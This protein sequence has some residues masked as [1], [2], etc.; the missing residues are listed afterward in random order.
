MRSSPP[1]FIILMIGVCLQPGFSANAFAQEHNPK[2]KP[3]QS[4]L[5]DKQLELWND[6]EFQRRFTESYIA[7]TDIEPTITVT[8]RE[9][10]LEIMELISSG[11]LDQA[12]RR[13]QESRNEASSAVFDFTLANIYFQQD[14]LDEAAPLYQ[15]AV[16]KYAKFRRAWKNLGI[17]H[18]RQKDFEKAIPALTRV[19]ELGD[20]QAITYGLLGFSYGSV[21]KFLPAESAYR[22][23]VLLDPETLD[24]KMGLARSFFKQERYAEA[25]SLCKILVEENPTKV[26]LWLLQANAYIGLNQPL[27]AAEIYEIVDQMGESTPDSLNML[28]DIYVNEKLFHLAAD[29]YIQAVGKEDQSGTDRAI[30]AAKILA[31]RGASDEAKRLIETIQSKY[32]DQLMDEEK[33]DLLKIEA[34]VAVA[35]GQAEEEVEV[36]KEIIQLDPLDGEA[37]ILLG[38]HSARKGDTEQAIFYY[39]RAASIEDFEADANIRRS[40]LLV[41]DGKYA[42]ALPLLRRAQQIN[43]RENVQEY[44]EQVERLA[45]SG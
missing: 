17:I 18:V 40:Q 16:E 31:A 24:W 10:M 12:A 43:P 36:L 8:E 5:S 7:E 6:P 37:L 26:D 35:E 9:T 42:E 38:Q 28:G 14:R 1:F 27:E 13:L 32:A 4:V 44:L 41:K 22:M 2:L 25:A 29:T 20:H 33:K 39:E 30:R 3:S 21:G 15:T 34:R 45:K 23:A 11:Q 19:V